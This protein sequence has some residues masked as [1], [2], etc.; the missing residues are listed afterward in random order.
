MRVPE[1][2]INPLSLLWHLDYALA[3]FLILAT[4]ILAGSR[5]SKKAPAKS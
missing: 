5:D 3:L 1:N 2:P 4:G